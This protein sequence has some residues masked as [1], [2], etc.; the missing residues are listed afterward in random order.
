MI[1]AFVESIKY[2]GHLFPIAFLR[3]FLGYFYLNEALLKLTGEYLKRPELAAMIREA[4]P[5]SGAPEWYKSI[6][7]Q[8]VVPQWPLFAYILMIMEFVVGLSYLFGYLVR[9]VGLL[10]FFMCLNL[11]MMGGPA[12]EALFKTFVVIHITLAWIGA[13]RCLGVDYYFFKRKSGLWW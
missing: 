11:L 3:I 12:T 5:T 9:P 8:Y 1:V 13:G 10:A 7:E 4:L 6:L 2:V